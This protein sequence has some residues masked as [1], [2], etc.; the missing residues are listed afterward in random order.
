MK[1]LKNLSLIAGEVK[2]YVRMKGQRWKDSCAHVRSYILQ[3]MDRFAA[4]CRGETLM[5]TDTNIFA[6][7]SFQKL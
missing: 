2:T 3:I 1:G 4:L 6:S 5:Q 7:I